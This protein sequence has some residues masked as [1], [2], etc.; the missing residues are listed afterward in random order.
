MEN[1]LNHFSPSAILDYHNCPRLFFLKHIL[2]LRIPTKQIHFLFGS[3]IHFALEG[4]YHNYKS[5]K[6][7]QKDIWKMFLEKFD[8]EKMMDDE[9]K[10]YDDYVKMGKAMLK[11]YLTVHPTL[12]N[13]YNLNDGESEVWVKGKLMNPLTGEMSSLP[14]FGIIDRLAGVEKIGNK[15]IVKEGQLPRIAEFKTAKN[16]W[17]EDD[18]A[19]KIQTLLYN[20]WFYTEF[21][22]LP[23]ETVYVILL[24]KIPKVGAQNHQV[25][26][27]RPTLVDLA[28]CWEEVEYT[29]DKINAGE[30]DRPTNK[31]HPPYCDCHRYEE[32][33]NLNK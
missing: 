31:W 23:E 1:K 21:E 22:Y 27:Q 2:K 29:L 6:D 5:G 18:L 30:F 26:I 9:K 11:H 17:K 10:D 4:M 12:N 14:M 15:I 16:K 13:L 24:K 3:A 8:K 32:F 19:F 20:L 33:L 25:L 28:C 7:D